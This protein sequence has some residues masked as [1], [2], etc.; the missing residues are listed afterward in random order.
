MTKK[1][2]ASKDS[3]YTRQGVRDLSYLKGKSRGIKLPDLPMEQFLPECR[4]ENLRY[5]PDKNYYECPACGACGSMFEE[6]TT[7]KYNKENKTK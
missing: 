1:R 7:N 2:S 4:H 6:E 5:F 3:G